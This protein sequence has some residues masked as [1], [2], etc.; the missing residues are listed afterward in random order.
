MHGCLLCLHMALWCTGY[1]P[2]QGKTGIERD[3]WKN[4]L[5]S[6]VMSWSSLFCL[7]NSLKST[8]IKV[9]AF[10]S[11][12]ALEQQIPLWYR[13]IMVFMEKK[14]L[15]PCVLFRAARSVLSQPVKQKIHVISCEPSPWSLECGNLQIFLYWI[16]HIIVVKKLTTEG[17]NQ[18]SHWNSFFPSPKWRELQASEVLSDFAF[19]AFF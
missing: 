5:M 6:E 15:I 9:W 10:D 16:N 8:H 13:K 18:S 19:R 3:V 4:T 14:P 12:T 7:T 1:L 2:E 11:A 17:Y